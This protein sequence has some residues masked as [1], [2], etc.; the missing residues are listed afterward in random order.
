METSSAEGS[1]RP[2]QAAATEL[3]RPLARRRRQAPAASTRPLLRSWQ[4]H[5]EP[6]PAARAEAVVAPPGPNRPGCARSRQGTEFAESRFRARRVTFVRRQR[7]YRRSPRS[8]SRGCCSARA[9]RPPH[10]CRDKRCSV[11]S[12]AT[13]PTTTSYAVAN[14]CEAG[15]PKGLGWQPLLGDCDSAPR[16]A[17]RPIPS[18]HNHVLRGHGPFRGTAEASV[19]RRPVQRGPQ[20][21]SLAGSGVR[22]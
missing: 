17:G 8:R 3:C 20:D 7:P 5:S 16:F 14:P 11:S 15:T 4:R 1:S 18:K 6:G 9:K 21:G 19:T 10:R 12:N 2:A 22:A 13:T